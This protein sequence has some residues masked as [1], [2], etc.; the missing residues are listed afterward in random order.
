VSAEYSVTVPDVE[1]F[2]RQV[3]CRSACPVQTDA[4]GYVQ[5]IAEG[6]DEDAYLIARRTNPFAS[7]CGRVCAAPCEAACRREAID[8]AIAIRALKRFVC[9]RHGVE[10]DDFEIGRIFSQEKLSERSRFGRGKRVAVVGAGPAG[11]ACAHDLALMGFAVT[12]FEAQK[13]AGGMLVLGIPEYRLPHAIIEAEI[14]AIVDLGVDIKLN[15]RLGVDFTLGALKREGFEAVFLAIGAH[16]SRE[17]NIEGT[18]LDGVFRAVDYLLNVN[19]GYQVNLHGKV[20]VV[21]GGSVAFDVARSV[22][23][24]AAEIDEMSPEAL[25]RVLREATSTLEQ[26]TEGEERGPEDL[27]VAFDVARQVL[28]AGVHDVHMYCLE[29]MDEIPATQVDIKEAMEE[30]VELHTG[31]GP[32]RILGRDGNVTGV[33]LIK[34]QSVFDSQGRFNPSFIEGSEERVTADGVVLAVGQAPDLSWIRSEDD[35]KISSRGTIDAD[36]ESMVTSRSDVFAGGDVAFG[37]RIVI[38][39]VAEGRRAAQSIAEFLCGRVS[40]ETTRIRSTIYDAHRMFPGYETL[41][42]KEPDVIAIDRRVGVTEVEKVLSQTRAREQ[43]RRCLSCHIS[44]IFDGDACV[45]CGG[46]V[47]VCPESCLRIVDVADMQGNESLSALIGAR[48][49]E[50]PKRGEAAAIIKNESRCIR[51]G[52]CAARCP[53]HAITME[54]VE[55]LQTA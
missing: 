28:R 14:K 47:D 41:S 8:S 22:V 21:G 20:I 24:Q 44:P 40:Q 16:K 34:V 26:L 33:E 5:A 36:P 30:G 31:W 39:A 9:E 18:D 27:K 45:L 2:E 35:I 48:Y 23:R 25:R 6:R 53:T 42:R 1:Y 43:A 15:H 17:L 46:C 32:R 52:L 3:L 50:I 13:T 11:L 49:R 37:P 29:S 51:C 55:A 7:V 19:Q 38:T 54:R 12:V 4:G 10:S